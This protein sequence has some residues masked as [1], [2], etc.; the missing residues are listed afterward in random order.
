MH[1]AQAYTAS[2]NPSWAVEGMADYARYKY[3][4]FNAQS[5][6]AL[7]A[8]SST[9]KYT[10]SYRVTARFFA[11]LE[12]HVRSTILLELD[13]TM[14]AGTYT[15]NFWVQMTGSTVDQLWSQYGANP[16]L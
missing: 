2:S 10:D 5:G 4:M 14:K 6:W 7:P 9:Q 12:L 16:T 13:D 1:V 15:A 3:G 8:Y 11:W